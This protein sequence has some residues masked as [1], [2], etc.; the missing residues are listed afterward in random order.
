V[1]FGR[2]RAWHW[3]VFLA[4][5]A[6]LFVTAMDWYSTTTGEEARRIE[7]L[8]EPEGAAGGQVERE[9]QEDARVTAEGAEKNAWQADGAID[10][11]ILVG[12]LLTAALGVVAAFAAARP[13]GGERGEPDRG[14]APDAGSEPERGREPE[15]ERASEPDPERGREADRGA[16]AAGLAG[17]AASATALL[18]TYRILQEPG[19]DASTTVQA[20]APVALVVLGVIALASALT[21]RAES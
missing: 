12:L 3:A 1:S 20:G 16:A 11:L 10:R 2:L 6:L 7:E 8:A 21:L 4:A 19:F 13:P 17:I 15:P 18:V 14:G 9:V 5:L